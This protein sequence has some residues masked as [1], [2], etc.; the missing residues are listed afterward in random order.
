MDGCT[1]QRLVAHHIFSGT[2]RYRKNLN[3]R[4]TRLRACVCVRLVR[5][6]KGQIKLKNTKIEH[7]STASVR[8]KNMSVSARARQMNQ[9][10]NIYIYIKP[11]VS[12]A[13]Q[14]NLFDLE[15]VLFIISSVGLFSVTSTQPHTSFH[16]QHNKTEL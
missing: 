10:E 7:V 11:F 13:Q 4:L 12:S 8:E 15:K 14:I 2:I 1:E 5:A 16:C 6:N 9:C 3:C